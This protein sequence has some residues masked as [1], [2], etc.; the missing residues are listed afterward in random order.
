VARQVAY[1]PGGFFYAGASA[2]EAAAAATMRLNFTMVDEATIEAAVADLGA[3]VAEA[4]E[5]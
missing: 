2:R 3:V 1:V 4:L 5:D